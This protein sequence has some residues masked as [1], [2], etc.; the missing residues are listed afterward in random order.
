MPRRA[1]PTAPIPTH[2]PY[3]VPMGRVFTARPSSATLPS[4]LRPVRSVGSGRVKPAVYF[5]PMAQP[6]SS[7][8]ATTRMIHAIEHLLRRLVVTGYGGALVR[9]APGATGTSVPGPELSRVSSVSRPAYT[10]G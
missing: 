2:T 3:A 7:R 1:A 10:P 4:M 9:A 6:T 8:P 5:R